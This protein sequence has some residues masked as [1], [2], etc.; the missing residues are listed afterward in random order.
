MSISPQSI[1]VTPDTQENYIVYDRVISENPDPQFNNNILVTADNCSNRLYFNMWY[2]FD[3]RDLLTKTIE[4]VWLSPDGTKGLSSV[5]EQKV[6][7]NDRLTFAWDVPNSATL[8]EGL[9][10]FAV[11]I[12]ADNYV[13]NSLIGTVE[14]KQGLVTTAFNDLPEAQAEPGWLEYIEGK[15]KLSIQSLTAQEY[16]DLTTKSNDVLYLVT[17]PDESIDMY[18]GDVQ[19]NTGGGGSGG[20]SYE[21]L[22][23]AQYDALAT[24]DPTTLY[25][26]TSDVGGPPGWTENVFVIYLGN[27]IL[28]NSGVPGNT[29]SKYTKKENF[30]DNNKSSISITLERCGRFLLYNFTLTLYKTSDLTALQ[31]AH[32][33]S[34]LFTDVPIIYCP[35]NSLTFLFPLT[36]AGYAQSVNLNPDAVAPCCYITGQPGESTDSNIKFVYLD[37]LSSELAQYVRLGRYQQSGCVLAYLDTQK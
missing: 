28:C 5:T 35:K 17:N 11:R 3:N 4:I 29:V 27:R 36:D 6:V 32:S 20:S 18:L 19:I 15:Y 34:R 10:Q 2:T 14:V 9:I 33:D 31:Q 12:T 30:G 8:R 13:W 1:I 16:E 37:D 23:Q 7:D 21:I 25:L 24:K 22:T 26:V